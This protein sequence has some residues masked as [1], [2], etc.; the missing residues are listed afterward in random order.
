MRFYKRIIF[1]QWLKSF[2]E[3]CNFLHHIAEKD[4]FN[5]SNFLPELHLFLQRKVYH[6]NTGSY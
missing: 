6:F 5:F 1:A 4:N 3:A 2:V